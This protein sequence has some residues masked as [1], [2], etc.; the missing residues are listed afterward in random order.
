MLH[1]RG[2]GKAACDLIHPRP[3]G[4]CTPL[5]APGPGAA[6]R[7][8]A[9]HAGGRHLWGGWR[10]SEGRAGP[11]WGARRARGGGARLPAPRRQGGQARPFRPGRELWARPGSAA[12]AARAAGSRAPG[13]GLVASRRPPAGLAPASGTALCL[14]GGGG[15]EGGSGRE[16]EVGPAAFLGI[17]WRHSLPPLG[18]V[19]GWELA[20]SS[21]KCLRATLLPGNF[22]LVSWPP[23]GDLPEGVSAG[24]RAPG[25]RRTLS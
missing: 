21:W 9:L 4:V 6:R 18:R 7:A 11:S 25:R 1:F 13:R 22:A 15:A 17:K 5:R 24:A 2:A 16:P 20:E 8:L 3:D 12:C 19:P 23:Q 10:G 14:A